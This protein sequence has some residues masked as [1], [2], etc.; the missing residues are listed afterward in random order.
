[1]VSW[2]EEASPALRYVFPALKSRRLERVIA[3]PGSSFVVQGTG[4]FIQDCC[5]RLIG[6]DACF[7]SDF[8]EHDPYFAFVAANSRQRMI[9]SLPVPESW[10][11]D[12][13]EK[14]IPLFGN[15]S[16]NW[17][18]WITEILPKAWLA[19]FLPPQYDDFCLLVP[20]RA[21]KG[22]FYEAL[23]C[24]SGERKLQI[25]KNTDVTIW[26]CLWI[27]SPSILPFN[28]K[29]SRWVFREVLSVACMK[30]RFFCIGSGYLIAFK[31]LHLRGRLIACF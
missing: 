10:K 5:H 31:V 2:Y 7:N 6:E 29:M 19:R 11:T 14:C 23:Q 24:V 22:T 21:A 15:G 1:M 28:V 17:Y 4:A 12:S 26:D 20:E 8:L 30:M 16:W 25:C 9:R 3:H 13:F 27:D 18:H